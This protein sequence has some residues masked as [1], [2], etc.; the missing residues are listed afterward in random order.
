MRT[1]RW[2]LGRCIALGAAS[3]IG[4]SGWLRGEPEIVP[5]ESGARAQS[6]SYNWTFGVSATDLVN[7]GQPTLRSMTGSFTSA[8]LNDGVHAP[9][10]DH[11]PSPNREL[12][13]TVFTLNV[14]TN[15]GGYDLD[16]L[17]LVF[18]RKIGAGGSGRSYEVWLSRVRDEGFVLL[19]EYV[20]GVTAAGGDPWQTTAWATDTWRA[21]AQGE[22]L[23]SGVDA[24]KFV[25]RYGMATAIDTIDVAGA[26]TVIRATGLTL[27]VR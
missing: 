9:T 19:G 17:Y 23:A 27:M 13:D 10:C 11:M 15:R 1:S 3:L 4:C 8:M 20:G 21:G 12:R 2:G 16:S 24:V 5:Y 14:A 6:F 25:W 22:S 26:P 18:G 7:A